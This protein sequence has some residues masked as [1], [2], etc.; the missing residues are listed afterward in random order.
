MLEMIIK[1]LCI[2]RINPTSSLVPPKFHGEIETTTKCLYLF[3]IYMLSDLDPMVVYI[4]PATT[5][6]PTW[7][8]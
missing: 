2:K 5:V 4:G 3:P 8:P 1:T 7:P 6:E